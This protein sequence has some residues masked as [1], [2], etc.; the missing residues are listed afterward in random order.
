MG[1]TCGKNGRDTEDEENGCV[2]S[3]AYKEER[4]TEI[5]MGGLREGTLGWSG[6]GV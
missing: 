4:K 5:E 6:R 2:L 1:W 3:G